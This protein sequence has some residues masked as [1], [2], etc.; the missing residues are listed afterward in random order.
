MKVSVRNGG[1]AG[2]V[3]GLGYLVQ[4]II[5][6]IKPQTDVFSGTSDYILEVVFIIALLAT[7]VGL[8]GLHAFAQNR[9]GKVGTVGF[10]L[11]VIGTGLMGISAVATLI[12]GQNS[13]GLFF[14]VGMILAMVGYITLG[15]MMMRTKFLPLW[16]GL[17]LLVGFPV[18]VS[19]STLSD[20]SSGI[21]FGLAWLGVGYYLLKK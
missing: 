1:I 10:W 5:G 2:I 16:I 12:A 13:L 19:V 7:I 9:Y 14:I 21:L 6:L 20:L 15:I 8:V 4:A 17:A 18:D 11:S 3:A